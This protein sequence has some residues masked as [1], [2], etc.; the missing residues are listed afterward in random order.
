ME[1]LTCGKS[2]VN[3]SSRTPV[4]LPKAHGEIHSRASVCPLDC[5][6]PLLDVSGASIGYP[7]FRGLPP[8]K[9]GRL[10]ASSVN[11]DLLSSCGGEPLE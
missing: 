8:P 9:I 11:A 2:A 5:S 4:A 3:R 10:V 7:G 1:W 6:E